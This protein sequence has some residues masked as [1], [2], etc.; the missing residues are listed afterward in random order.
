MAAEGK[1]YR[2]DDA[3]LIYVARFCTTP[4]AHY[5]QDK[6]IL[7]SNSSRKYGNC[8]RECFGRPRL[9]NVPAGQ[10]QFEVLDR[11]WYRLVW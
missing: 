6:G 2:I 1:L 4:A 3:L 9:V 5:I 7:W 10:A 8:A 11:P